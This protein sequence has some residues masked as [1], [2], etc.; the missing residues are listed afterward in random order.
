MSRLPFFIA[1]LPAALVPLLFDSALKGLVLLLVATLAALSLWRA[2]ASTR[3]L[4]WLVAI[5]ALLVVP[6]L[7]VA[8]PGWRILPEWAAAGAPV[9]IPAPVI[10]PP[11]PVPSPVA[12]GAAV[13]PSIHPVVT[14]PAPKNVTA[15]PVFPILRETTP[16]PSSVQMPAE[17]TTGPWLS[18]VWLAGCVLLLTRLVIARIYLQR[19]LRRCVPVNGGPLSLA[20]REAACLLGVRQSVR[21][22]LDDHCAM[23]VVWGVLRPRLVLP[24]SAGEWDAAQLRSVLLHELAHIRRRDTAIQCLTQCACALHWFNPLVWVAAWRIHGERERACDDLVISCGV[25][26]SEYAGHLLQVA[27]RF[28]PAPW[29]AACGLAMARKSRLEGRLL[30][31]LSDRLSRRRTS[32]AFVAAALLVGAGI[33]IPLAM[34]RAGEPDK[35]SAPAAGVPREESPPPPSAPSPDKAAAPDPDAGVPSDYLLFDDTQAAY[36]VR[37]KGGVNFV[38]YHQGFLSTGV[39][40]SLSGSDGGPKTWKFEGILQIKD[41]EAFRTSRVDKVKREFQVLYSS[42]DPDTLYLDGEAFPLRPSME[43]TP[44]NPDKSGRVFILNESGKPLQTGRTLPLRNLKDLGT[45]GDFVLQDRH[46]EEIYRE[47]RKVRETG[48]WLLAWDE[49]HPAQHGDGQRVARLRIFPDGRVV[50][51]PDGRSVHEL[52]MTAGDVDELMIRLV[53]GHSL[54]EW[55]TRTVKS[56]AGDLEIEDPLNLWDAST[57]ILKVRREGKML[58]LSISSGPKNPEGPA[59]VEIEKLL[60]RTA[61]IAAVGGQ[62]GLKKYLLYATKNVTHAPEE[63]DL[64]DVSFGDDGSLNVTF[65]L[66]GEDLSGG[67]IVLRFWPASPSRRQVIRTWNAGAGTETTT[68]TYED[69]SLVS[70]THEISSRASA[71][72]GRTVSNWLMMESR[73]RE[74]GDFKTAMK[75]YK[76]AVETDAVSAIGEGTGPVTPLMLASAAGDLVKVKQ[77][78]AAGEDPNSRTPEKNF[79]G[80]RNGGMT[81]L[82][83]ACRGGYYEVAKALLERGAKVENARA[84]SQRFPLLESLTTA[85]DE[86]AAERFMTLLLDHGADPN[87]AEDAIGDALDLASS[88]NWRKVMRLLVS[89]GANPD[90]ERKL[91]SGSITLTTPGTP[92]LEELRKEFAGDSKPLVRK[93]DDWS[94]AFLKLSRTIAEAR[95]VPAAKPEDLVAWGPEK[96]GLR[97]GLLLGP[98]VNDGDQLPSML[99][100]RSLSTQS[101]ELKVVWS[102]NATKLK[103]RDADGKDLKVTN[104]EL[105]GLDLVV[106]VTLQPNEQIEIPGPPVK[107]GGPSPEGLYLHTETPGGLVRARMELS[108]LPGIVTGEIPVTITREPAGP[109]GK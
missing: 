5:L 52:R 38:L 47:N 70:T 45:I 88:L 50:W 65:S 39:S 7:S 97:A 102:W 56:P 46:L 109:S 67:K 87:D 55:K 107:F 22:F 19:A 25:R 17:P 20:L 98:S 84:A 44:R 91:K 42:A 51:S 8:L 36:A 72:S 48:G 16:A 59:F 27:T 71:G 40:F 80:K 26:P 101:R 31:V 89:H 18:L 85:A 29:T 99:V 62:E 3:H 30:A 78:L 93:R 74:T 100:L 96:E 103:T 43:E 76:Q 75:S 12:R 108:F 95:E 86:T 105:F 104:L 21:L 69:D 6:V 82:L 83:L 37:T 9:P 66:K 34:L 10:Q 68:N 54:P 61:W 79:F 63:K 11:A 81:P 58:G 60:T 106:P 90:P 49:Q 2:S 64:S 14:A 73:L 23:P 4:V 28:T 32:A 33:A 53:S 35:A 15:A 77:L 41:V 92:Y 57:N 13:A 24:S 94:P 1:L